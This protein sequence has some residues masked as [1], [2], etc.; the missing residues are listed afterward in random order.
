MSLLVG[1]RE[2]FWSHFSFLYLILDLEKLVPVM[3]KVVMW[4]TRRKKAYEL[5]DK[6]RY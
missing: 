5:K 1:V 6:Y 3:W 4:F 2:D